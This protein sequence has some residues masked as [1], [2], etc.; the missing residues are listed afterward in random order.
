MATTNNIEKKRF[1]YLFVRLVVVLLVIGSVLA[2]LYHKFGKERLNFIVE[3]AIYVNENNSYVMGFYKEHPHKYI[4]I[5]WDLKS[6]PILHK[7]D[8]IPTNVS[9]LELNYQLKNF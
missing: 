6:N 4:I 3:R 2:F 9:K 8:T 1:P 7:G 5:R